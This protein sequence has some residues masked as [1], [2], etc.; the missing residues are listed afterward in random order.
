[1]T[2]ATVRSVAVRRALSRADPNPP[3]RERYTERRESSPTSLTS[4]WPIWP[5]GQKGEVVETD[6]D[7]RDARQSANDRT[8]NLM[9]GLGALDGAFLCECTRTGCVQE[10]VLSPSEFMGHRRRDEPICVAGHENATRWGREE[11]RHPSNG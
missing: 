8:Y 11:R 2:W 1:M 9:W 5:G 3:D 4:D 6:G 7:K 10:T